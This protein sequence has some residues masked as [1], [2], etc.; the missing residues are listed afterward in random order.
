[1]P[2]KNESAPTRAK[3]SSRLLDRVWDLH[4]EYVESV[5]ASS[6]SPASKAD[7]IYFSNLFVRWLDYD[8]EPGQGLAP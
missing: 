5:N 6:L 2:T 4:N 1:M 8:Y 3:A 7:L